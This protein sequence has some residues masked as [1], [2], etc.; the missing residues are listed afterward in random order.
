MRNALILICSGLLLCTACDDKEKAAPPATA[1]S[2]QAP[3]ASAKAEAPKPAAAPAASAAPAPKVE[4]EI[5]SVGDTMA[6]D[7]TKLTVPAG[8]EVHLRFK[9]NGKQ[10]VMQHN[11][12]LV[13]PGKEAAVA[14]E[15]LAKAPTAGY[16]V[17]GP[18]VLAFAPITKPGETSE[19]TFKAPAPGAYPYICTYPGHYIL[20]HGVLTVTP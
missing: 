9:N 19:V 2:S 8:S 10:E 16:L 1:A 4:L 18:D 5:A 7:K 12:V 13:N 11:W 17:P 15:G 3:A 20:M 14:A 6:F